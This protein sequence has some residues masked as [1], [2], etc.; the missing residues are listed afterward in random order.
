MIFH[1]LKTHHFSI[2]FVLHGSAVSLLLGVEY[3]EGVAFSAV[4]HVEAGV[5]S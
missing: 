3:H 4:V 5:S 1:Y 2:V